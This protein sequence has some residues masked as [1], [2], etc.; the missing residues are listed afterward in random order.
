MVVIST[1]PCEGDASDYIHGGCGLDEAAPVEAAQADI[2]IIWGPEVADDEVVA[3]D[4]VL[5]ELVELDGVLVC[6][7][8]DIAVQHEPKRLVPVQ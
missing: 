4:G 2:C 6:V 8:D 1:P 5:A 7:V 3:D